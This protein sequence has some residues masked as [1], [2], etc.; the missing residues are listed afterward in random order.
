[1]S[2]YCFNFD[3][4]QLNVKRITFHVTS[5]KHHFAHTMKQRCTLER[6]A[7]GQWPAVPRCDD[8]L[9]QAML[10]QISDGQSIVL[11]NRI[12]NH[13]TYI[14]LL[15]FSPLSPKGITFLYAS[16]I[17]S[18]GECDRVESLTLCFAYRPIVLTV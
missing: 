16:C 8:Q 5:Y 11:R 18:S 9:I 15:F 14:L 10:C 6:N 17:L 4:A 1:M 13:K 3:N 2:N 12:R 7:P